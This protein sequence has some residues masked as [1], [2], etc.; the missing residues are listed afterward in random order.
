MRRPDSKKAT[1][2]RHSFEG[3]DK[4]IEWR[5]CVQEWRPHNLDKKSRD[6]F[7]A[8]RSADSQMERERESIEPHSGWL[9]LFVH[10]YGHVHWVLR[11]RRKP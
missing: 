11:L 10:I 5:R 1:A 8:G 9:E 6:Q 2:R 3:L 4:S 7:I